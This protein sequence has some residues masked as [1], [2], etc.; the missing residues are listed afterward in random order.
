MCFLLGITSEQTEE[1]VKG[2][3]R[4][5]RGREGKVNL[6][7]HKSSLKELNIFKILSLNSGLGLRC[8]H[9]YICVCT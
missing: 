8:L 4:I 2:K 9:R 1:Q 5:K 6:L 3:R 7:L